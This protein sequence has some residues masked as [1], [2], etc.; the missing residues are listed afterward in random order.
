[1]RSGRGR[2]PGPLALAGLVGLGILYHS[3]SDAMDKHPGA[4]TAEQVRQAFEAAREG[5]FGPSS[6]LQSLGRE[7]LPHL[8]PYLDDPDPDI[9][10]QAV[11]LAGLIGGKAA[12]PLLT[13]ALTLSDPD[14][15]RRAAQALYQGDPARLAGHAALGEALRAQVAGGAPAAAAVLLLGYF[16]GAGAETAL[17]GLRDRDPAALAELAQWGPTVPMALAV[18]VALSRLGDPRARAALL[19][20]IEQ[21][22]LEELRFLLEVLREID[23]PELLH[24]LKRTLDD[25]RT[26]AGGVPS[27]AQLR[28]R[29]RDAA[30]DAFVKRLDLAVDFQLNP[31]GRYGDQQAAA[32]RRGIEAALPR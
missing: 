3:G 9:R 13:R 18:N 14:L 2:G 28:R 21:G 29:L 5:D 24:A 11:A 4:Q 6:E 19:E 10:R 15:Q 8:A 22:G 20:T 16:P 17:R 23:A 7:A 27:G 1:M 26:I 12:V 31:A 25:T 30:V 32:V